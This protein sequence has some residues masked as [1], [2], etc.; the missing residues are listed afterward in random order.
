LKGISPFRESAEKSKE[1]ELRRNRRRYLTTKPGSS[2]ALTAAFREQ[3]AVGV[4][5]PPSS[6][7]EVFARYRQFRE[8][9]KQHHHEILACISTDALLNQARRL[10]LAQGKTLILE[11]MEEM[12]YVYDLAIHTA[13][14]QRSRAI[15]RF[16]GLA[17]FAPGSDEALV[18]AAM[19][20]ARF[21]V[22]LIDRHHETAGL[23][24]TDLFRG[25]EVWLVDIGLESSLSAG[26]ML[27]TRL[28]TPAHFSMT[29][30]TYV[31]FEVEMLTDILDELPR[32]LGDGPLEA[33]ANNRHF[34][35]A[36]YRI[37]LA[38]GIMDRVAYQD[39]SGDA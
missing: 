36:I 10:G 11:D 29:T 4:D 18:L 24:A 25:T 15:D 9:S 2:M 22:L 1:D 23:V 38:D 27:A 35:E 26:E 6:R 19:R 5:D 16:A 8:I 28:F 17:W 12:N 34:A 30:G 7:D 20:A 14:P 3:S 21:S 13:S 39:L 32:R 33:L 37:A 31:P